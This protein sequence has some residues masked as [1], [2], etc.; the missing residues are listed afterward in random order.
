ME[1]EQTNNINKEDVKGQNQ[2]LLS[3]IKKKNPLNWGVLDVAE[4][5][6]HRDCKELIS[7]KT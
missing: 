4:S 7:K 3:D 1:K 6:Q 5:V 2:N